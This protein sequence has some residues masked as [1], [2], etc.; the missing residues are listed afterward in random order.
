MKKK[1][2]RVASAFLLSLA[3]L[4]I[5]TGCGTNDVNINQY[6]RT[7]YG[8]KGSALEGKSGTYEYYK[9]ADASKPRRDGK[10]ETIYKATSYD[11]DVYYV[12]K[13]TVNKKWY[14]SSSY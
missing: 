6:R 8:L 2:F 9:T 5:L 3:S 7:W 1:L 14:I 13:S 12:W 11:G 4:S 10:K